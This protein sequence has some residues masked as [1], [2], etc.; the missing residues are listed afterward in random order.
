MKKI[1][2][3]WQEN[4]VLLVLAIILIVCLVV[5][6]VVAISF[7]YGSN[8]DPYG[9]R[10]DIT[11]QVPLSNQTLNDI[12]NALNEKENVQKCDTKLVGRVVYIN[13]NFNDGVSMDDAKATAESTVDMFSDELLE[14]YDLEITISSLSTGDSLGYTLM[15]AY[16]ASG[17]KHL[18][19]NNYNLEGTSA[20]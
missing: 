17:S 20:E 16:N 9:N 11:K 3:I 2:K 7:F 1:K 8:N 5:F 15:G 12:E 10:L 4:K 19:W 6:A 14:V 18:V 13:I